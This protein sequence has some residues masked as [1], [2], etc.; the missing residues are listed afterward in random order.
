MN[1]GAQL[2]FKIAQISHLRYI[3]ARPACPQRHAALLRLGL[4]LN[5]RGVASASYEE[6]V[7]GFLRGLGRTA[8][9]AGRFSG[10][11]GLVSVSLYSGPGY[12]HLN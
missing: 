8:A 4:K 5:S 9:G 12:L 2:T 6:L 11:S 1:H 3:P 10:T 7:F